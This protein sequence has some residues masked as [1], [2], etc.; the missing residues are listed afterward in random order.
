MFIFARELEQQI[1]EVKDQIR[2][3][4]MPQND[5]RRQLEELSRK[6]GEKKREKQ[7]IQTAI[8]AKTNDI[9]SLEEDISSSNEK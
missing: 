5:I 4:S 3:Q 1:H 6:Y 2:V 8:D 9:K 7:Q